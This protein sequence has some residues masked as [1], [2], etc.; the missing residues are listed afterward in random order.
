MLQVTVDESGLKLDLEEKLTGSIWAG[1]YT[2]EKLEE[3][4]QKTGS[5]KEFARFSQMLIDAVLQPN[6]TEVKV[7]LLTCQDLEQLRRAHGGGG[8]S[9][10]PVNNNR[11]F[12]V[13]NYKTIYDKVHYPLTLS[14]EEVPQERLRLRFVIRKLRSELEI[15]KR[16]G[17]PNSL[18]DDWMKESVSYKQ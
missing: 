4:T 18:T 17:T 12:L 7:D 1:Q 8:K 14:F 9:M 5:F 13:L 10:Q 3:L 15:Y 11:R 2:P 6:N 16:G